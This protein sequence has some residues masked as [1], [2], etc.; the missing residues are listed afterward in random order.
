MSQW[1]KS[2]EMKRARLRRRQ[3]QGDHASKPGSSLKIDPTVVSDWEYVGNRKAKQN[4]DRE[5]KQELELELYTPSTVLDI[6]FILCAFLPTVMLQRAT[7][8]S[9][10]SLA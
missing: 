2:K 5:V 6:H 8:V 10:L 9:L 4:L 1:Q 3:T 7:C